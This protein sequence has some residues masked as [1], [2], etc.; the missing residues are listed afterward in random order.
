MTET[1]AIT[2]VLDFLE[3]I[4]FVGLLII[5]AIPKFRK[6]FFNGN[7]SGELKEIRENHLKHISDDMRGMNNMITEF[8]KIDREFHIK[9]D[10][11]TDQIID[12]LKALNRK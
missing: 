11:K 7:G 10:I 8:I 9:Q 6:F 4:G 3:T 5:L 12:L 1:I 2:N